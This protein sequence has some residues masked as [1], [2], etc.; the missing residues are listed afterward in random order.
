MIFKGSNFG[1]GDIYIC[2]CGHELK[3]LFRSWWLHGSR[4]PKA[5]DSGFLHSLGHESLASTECVKNTL[6]TSFINVLLSE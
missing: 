1:T 4:S 2:Q 3:Y 5:C 6:K